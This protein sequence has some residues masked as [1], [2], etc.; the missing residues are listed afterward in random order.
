MKKYIYIARKK[1]LLKACG[2]RLENR[3]LLRTPGL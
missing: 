2:V 3:K 1:K